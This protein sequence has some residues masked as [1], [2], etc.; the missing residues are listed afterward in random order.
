[1][2]DEQDDFLLA[3]VLQLLYIVPL[4]CTVV[5]PHVVLGVRI[6]LRVYMLS[7]LARVVIFMAE[8]ASLYQI[9]SIHLVI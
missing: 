4:K 2:H 7:W 5:S 8:L 3:Y 6:S 1:M 9:A